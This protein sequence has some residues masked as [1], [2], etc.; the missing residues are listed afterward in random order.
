M[1][2]ARVGVRR[3]LAIGGVSISSRLIGKS[4][5]FHENGHEVSVI[6]PNNED[7]NRLKAGG[8][9]VT[10]TSRARLITSKNGTKFERVTALY[11]NR[12]YMFVRAH[13]KDEHHFFANGELR[14][15]HEFN[16]FLHRDTAQSKSLRDAGAK[17]AR[18]GESAAERWIETLRWRTGNSLA[19]I[20]EETSVRIGF[21]NSYEFISLNPLRGFNY[22]S[23]VATFYDLPPVMPKDW[24]RIGE[25]LNAD[26]RPPVWIMYKYD[27]LRR[28]CV[29]DRV[30]ALLSCAVC[31]ESYLRAKIE[32]TLSRIPNGNEAIKRSIRRMQISDI[33]GGFSEFSN[34]RALLVAETTLSE[35]RATFQI[36]NEIMHG[37]RQSVSQVELDRALTATRT[38]VQ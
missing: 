16:S 12:M 6:I 27:S 24:R 8:A 4:L 7:I 14:T 30:G 32:N 38:L 28:E 9:E 17:L 3:T 18:I 10:K 29:G 36:R 34:L 21:E 33:L 22:L 19:S 2:G 1:R 11:I 35:I 15:R 25:S 37:R 31:I 13:A 20:G 5:S 23:G 26:E